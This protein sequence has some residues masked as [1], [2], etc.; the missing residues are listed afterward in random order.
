MQRSRDATAA[1]RAG[2]QQVVH[3]RHQKEIKQMEVN[4]G[5]A[6]FIQQPKAK[7]CVPLHCHYIVTMSLRTVPSEEGNNCIINISEHM[8]MLMLIVNLIGQIFPRY[9]AA[10]LPN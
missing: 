9:E 6:V 4:C 5:Q 3:G 8:L 2:G 10:L 7:T 1:G